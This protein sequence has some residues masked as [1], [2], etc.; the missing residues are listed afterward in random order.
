MKRISPI[1]CGILLLHIGFFVFG[2]MLVLTAPDIGGYFD[3]RD[4]EAFCTVEGTVRDAYESRDGDAYYLLIETPEN[5][6]SY[7]GDYVLRDRMWNIARENGLD[8]PPREG[9]TVSL[10][11]HPAYLGDGWS[12]PIAALTVNG[13]TYLPFDEGYPAVLD[14]QR[15]AAGF[16]VLAIGLG[17]WIMIGA[18]AMIAVGARPNGRRSQPKKNLFRP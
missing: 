14:D 12:Y 8:A 10:T 5:E 18:V 3:Y 16:S 1:L 17:V 4:R 11:F 2:V 13:T 7:Y 9:D 15:G 6:K